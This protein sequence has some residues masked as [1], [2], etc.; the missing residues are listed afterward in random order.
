MAQ[1]WADQVKTI[2]E[3]GGYVRKRIA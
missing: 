3:M 2:L 1:S